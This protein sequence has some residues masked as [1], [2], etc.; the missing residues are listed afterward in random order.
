MLDYVET[1]IPEKNEKLSIGDLSMMYSNIQTDIQRLNTHIGSFRETLCNYQLSLERQ[2]EI[3]NI[4]NYIVLDTETTG[5]PMKRINV[6]QISDTY[7]Y[8]TA[9]M[10]QFSWGMYDRDGKLIQTNDHIIKPENYEVRSTEIH[11][12]TKEIANRGEKFVKILGKFLDDM[13]KAKYLIG[14][15]IEFDINVL[16]NEC[17]NRNMM[18]EMKMIDGKKTICTMKTCKNLV[19]SKS[20]IGRSKNPTQHELFEFVMGR[21]MENAHNSK[22]DVLNLGMVV[23]RL[24]NV[25]FLIL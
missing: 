13:G 7:A 3:V 8:A 16:K 25:K 20:K 14:H 2:K 19:N 24:I 6:N 9:R 23:S 21:E 17:L 15:N 11:G 10:L 18:D 4:S 12:I 5:L 1:P 22:Y